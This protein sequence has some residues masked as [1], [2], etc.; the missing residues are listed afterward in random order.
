[1]T[2]GLRLALALAAWVAAAAAPAQTWPQKPVRLVVSAVAGGSLDIPI[3]FTRPL[4][5]GGS[6]TAG[7]RNA[8][9]TSQL[10]SAVAAGTEPL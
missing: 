1:M 9:W 8:A 10:A 7:G 3:S 5:T 6:I 4:W 2:N